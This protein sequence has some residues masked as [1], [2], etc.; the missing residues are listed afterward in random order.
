LFVDKL[1]DIGQETDLL[2][3]AKDIRDE[4]NMIGS[5][6]EHQKQVLLDLQEAIC[7]LYLGEHKSQA[8]IKKRFRE[9]QRLIEMHM[10]DVDRMNK[11]TERI[12]HSITDL[13]DLKQKHANAFEARFARDQAAGTTRQGKTIMMFTIVTIIFLPLSFIASFFA[14]NV[15]EFPH[16]SNSTSLPLSYVVKY[17]FGI[18]FS[19]SIPMI[20]LALS[21]DDIRDGFR[22]ALL[23][24]RRWRARHRSSTN[25][26]LSTSGRGGGGNQADLAPQALEIERILSAAKARRS[27]ES[28]YLGGGLLPVA[29]RDTTRSQIPSHRNHGEMGL[30]P[31]EKGFNSRKSNQYDRE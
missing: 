24:I 23:R 5:V 21:V 25:R 18:G 7:E 30:G 28:N 15:A 29:T 26:R 10:K 31:L 17:I 16:D 1:L 19:I 4:L 3:E 11:Q 27:V 9:Q 14:I 2:A 22:E 12:Y 6:L 8:E 20:I 13:L